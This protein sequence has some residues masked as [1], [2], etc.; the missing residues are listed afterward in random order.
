MKEKVI[1]RPRIINFLNSL[2]SLFIVKS[3]A[4]F[5]SRIKGP[6]HICFYTGGWQFASCEVQ[7]CLGADSEAK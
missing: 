4:Q 1:T 5:L 2:Q 3:F 6:E 7:C